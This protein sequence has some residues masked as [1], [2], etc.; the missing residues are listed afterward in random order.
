[1]IKSFCIKT[2]N[3]NIL[4]HILGSFKSN[5]PANFYLSRNKFKVYE[6]VII[7]YTGND[8]GT[9]YTYVSTLIQNVILY[10]YE[11][12]ILTNFINYDYFYF[13]DIEKKAIFKISKELLTEN[14]NLYSPRINTLYHLCYTYVKSNK[15][16]ILDGFINFRL[17]E[18]TIALNELIAEAASNF[19]IQKEYNE[20]IDLLKSYVNTT[21]S[22]AKEVHLVYLNEES[23]LLDEHKNIIEADKSIS[24]AK[25]LSDITFS[26][27]DYCLNTLLNLLPKRIYIHALNNNGNTEFLDTLCAIFGKRIIICLDC[28]ICNYYKANDISKKNN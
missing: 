23:L 6:N 24:N 15:S 13:T 12:K 1:M 14:E 17:R 11:D 10:F 22:T 26:S 4:N 21:P 2:N 19:T 9:F 7:H 28:S 18:Y 20:F 3:H 8:I 25:Y 5:P 16:M 27:N